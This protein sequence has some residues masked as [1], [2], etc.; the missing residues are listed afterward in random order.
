MPDPTTDSKTSSRFMP[1]PGDEAKALDVERSA[2][3]YLHDRDE[4]LGVL[5]SL[6][7]DTKG[8]K[9]Q[10]ALWNAYQRVGALDPVDAATQHINSSPPDMELREVAGLRAKI[11]ALIYRHSEKTVDER[12]A[13]DW[14]EEYEVLTAEIATALNTPSTDHRKPEGD[15]RGEV[16]FAAEAGVK[17]V[18]RP[19]STDYELVMPTGNRNIWFTDK[20]AA[21]YCA[22][23]VGSCWLEAEA[24]GAANERA[25]NPTPHEGGTEGGRWEA[26]QYD[27]RTG[28][29]EQPEYR[30]R[31]SLTG[32]I[33]HRGYSD[34]D[35]AEQLA[36]DLNA[37][38][39][40]H[41]A[42]ASSGSGEAVKESIEIVL[43]EGCNPIT[44]HEL[45]ALYSL[46]GDHPAAD[47]V[48]ASVRKKLSHTLMAL[49]EGAVS[50][51]YKD[52]WMADHFATQNPDGGSG[53]SF[54]LR[55]RID[56]IT[57]MATR[58]TGSAT[59]Q[60]TDVAAALTELANDLAATNPT[61]EGHVAVYLPVATAK[62]FSAERQDESDTVFDED[63]RILY[64][65]ARQALSNGEGS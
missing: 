49:P 25:A 52:Y 51:E 15:D 61:P 41:A 32:I 3:P 58:V 27:R 59:H 46:T 57:N 23:V 2:L 22:Q 53:V 10:Q 33:D 64:R 26:F 28:W 36:N 6:A 34:L 38:E 44:P 50:D 56:G 17:I 11:E 35:D 8:K 55:R 5:E 21:I 4:V 24:A 63:E 1:E 14:R 54:K 37:K 31:D 45:H 29:D 48:V 39:A 20:E 40:A 12:D 62:N 7:T 18:Q 19:D 9:V 42:G 13:M 60:L 47:E 43:C 65:A 30:V 16:I